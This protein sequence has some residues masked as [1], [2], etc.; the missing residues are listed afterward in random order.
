MVRTC[1]VKSVIGAWWLVGFEGIPMLK[2]HHLP[3]RVID[4][5]KIT[6]YNFFFR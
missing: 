5:P 4:N 2:L 3:P 1:V 6:Q